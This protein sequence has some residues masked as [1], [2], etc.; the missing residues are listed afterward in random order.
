ME[1]KRKR[2]E[3]ESLVSHQDAQEAA[4]EEGRR[5]MNERQKEKGPS[6]FQPRDRQKGGR[7]VTNVALFKSECC[8]FGL[9]LK[10]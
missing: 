9:E 2:K 4:R 6:S 3:R 1:K 5:E 7:C 8:I 10:S